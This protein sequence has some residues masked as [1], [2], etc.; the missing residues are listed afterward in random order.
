MPFT[1]VPPPVSVFCDYQ[2]I[3]YDHM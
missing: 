3:F 1:H 2:L